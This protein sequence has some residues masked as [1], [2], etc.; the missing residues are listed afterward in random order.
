MKLA[1]ICSPTPQKYVSTLEDHCVMIVDPNANPNRKQYLIGAVDWSLLITDQET[2]V[3]SGR[4]YVDTKLIW[5]TSGTTGES[6]FYQFSQSQL[7]LKVQT[8][9]QAY[10]LSPDDHYVSIMPL[11]HGHGQGLFWASLRAKSKISFLLPQQIQDLH[12]FRPTWISCIPSLFPFVLK[13]SLDDL[14]FIR[15]SSQ[16]LPNDLYYKLQHKFNVPIIETF[17]MTEALSH[18]FTNPLKGEQRIGTVGLPDGIECRIDFEHN[19][20]IKGPCVYTP[21]WINTGDLAEQDEKKY[22]R[23][24]G[25]SIDQI[26]IK[27]VKVN[28]VSL[29]NLLRN[30]FPAIEQV[31][32]FGEDRVKCVYVGSVESEEIKVYLR[33]TAPHL[34]P[35]FIRQELEIP[36]N[37]SGKIS[38]RYLD[39]IYSQ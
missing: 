20:W 18:C 24:I 30:R 11:W 5:Y 7:D 31:V 37:N 25:R 34:H 32:V 6:K 39:L 38:R 26:N 12:R 22:Y 3:R 28:P 1:V 21:N 17:G 33:S 16:S 10:D 14:R 13:Q 2:T 29:E 23:I 35:R 8:I 19:L 36:V 9:I 4:D 27:G 15:S